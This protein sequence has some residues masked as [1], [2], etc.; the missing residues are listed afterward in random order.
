MVL[1]FL[2][3]FLKGSQPVFNFLCLPFYLVVDR[4]VL[5]VFAKI[6]PN[7]S[8]QLVMQN[9]E[10]VPFLSCLKVKL[11]RPQS[12]FFYFGKQDLSGLL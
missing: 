1:I 3:L 4:L 11:G 2:T 6:L 8:K 7:L 5:P 9:F 10:L 12:L